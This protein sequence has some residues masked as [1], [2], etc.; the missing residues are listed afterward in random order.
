MQ[1][2][3]EQIKTLLK[4][5]KQIDENAKFLLVQQIMRAL[6]PQLHLENEPLAVASFKTLVEFLVMWGISARLP[7]GIGINPNKRFQ[8]FKCMA[9]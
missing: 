8:F 6:R 7:L 3:L 5:H 1:Q 9:K 4:E 2:V